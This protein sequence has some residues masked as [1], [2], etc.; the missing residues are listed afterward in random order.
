MEASGTNTPGFRKY[1]AKVNVLPH[2]SLSVGGD[3]GYF[4]NI[5]EMTG[6]SYPRIHSRCR[7]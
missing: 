1:A 7:R 5:L 3:A 6:S 4:P 2:L